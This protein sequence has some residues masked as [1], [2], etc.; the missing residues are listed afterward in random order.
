MLRA[1][2]RTNCYSA[3]GKLLRCY[4]S[5]SGLS[6]ASSQRA[7]LEQYASANVCWSPALKLIDLCLLQGHVLVVEAFGGVIRLQ[8][9]AVLM[10]VRSEL[11]ALSEVLHPTCSATR[12]LSV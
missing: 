1:C 10:G 6:T 2:I 7:T 12:R 4:L 5:A 11:P 9:K 3:N 8:A